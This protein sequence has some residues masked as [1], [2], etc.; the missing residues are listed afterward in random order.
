MIEKRRRGHPTRAEM[1]L[2]P[3]VI[4]ALELRAGGASWVEAA[5]GAGIQ[6]RYLRK[7]RDL[8]EA[9]QWL[10]RRIRENLEQAQARLVDSA[11]AVANRLL[12]IALDPTTKAYAAV[13]AAE[14]IF[15]IIQSGVIESEQRQQL[16]QI[17]QQ[18]AALEATGPVID[19]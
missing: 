5:N 10:E 2:T 14:S 17:R 18:L 7:W 11:P 12:E 16:Q 8:P 3:R 6:P 9:Q 1:G 19:V 13:S 15:R 4:A